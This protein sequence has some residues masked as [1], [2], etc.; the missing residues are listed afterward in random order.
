MTH[1]LQFAQPLLLFL[2][3]LPFGAQPAVTLQQEKGDE[4]LRANTYEG[5]RIMRRCQLGTRGMPAATVDASPRPPDPHACLVP[6][7]L[8]VMTPRVLRELSVA[9]DPCMLY[10][11]S[12]VRGVQGSKEGGQAPA[13]GGGGGGGAAASHHTPR[14]RALCSA[15]P[16]T[17]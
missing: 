4:V 3:F 9:H 15:S 17:A 11:S 13:A 16:W 14:P 5:R 12:G 2:F 6:V 8:Q 7:L 10:N 1:L